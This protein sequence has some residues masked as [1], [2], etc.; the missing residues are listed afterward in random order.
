MGSIVGLD[1]VEKRKALPL[2]GIES[3]TSSSQ[4]VAIPKKLFTNNL[5]TWH[6]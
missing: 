3:R 2:S 1:A 5:I 4:P 6:C